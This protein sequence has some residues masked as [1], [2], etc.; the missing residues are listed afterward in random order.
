VEREALHW[1]AVAVIE[2]DGP[3]GGS[4]LFVRRAVRAG[5]PWSGDMAFPGG[6][7]RADDP[8]PAA[9]ARRET[10]EELG[11]ELGEPV[12]QLAPRWAFD[13]RTWRPV[14]LY[15]IRFAAPE[16]ELRPDPREIAEARWIAWPALLA[17]RREWLRIRGVVPWYARVRRADGARIWGLTGRMIDDLV[18]GGR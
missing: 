3:E 18:R 8:D 1:A 12:G 9:T 10:R 5:D 7:R 17:P 11:L 6:F 14:P 4:L 13:P 2:R 15:P 16:G